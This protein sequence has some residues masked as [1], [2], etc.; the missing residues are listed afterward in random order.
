[1]KRHGV[2]LAEIILAL[3]VLLVAFVYTFSV[4]SSSA[5]QAVQS[6]DRKLALLTAQSLLEEVRAH[7]WGRPAPKQWP[8]DKPGK[9]QYQFTVSKRP[10][11][12]EY[13]VELKLE[14]GALIGKVEGPSDKATVT[15][16]WIEKGPHEISADLLLA[17]PL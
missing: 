10:Q 17:S 12:C 15:V 8:L 2:G 6:R 1:M 5:R 3:A 13:E 7:A 4:F 9:V 14:T 11:E 16:R